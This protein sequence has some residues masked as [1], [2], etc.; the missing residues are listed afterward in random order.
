[1]QRHAKKGTGVS[2]K[3]LKESW[4]GSVE[5]IEE[6]EQQGKVLVIRAGKENQP[7][8]VFW[9][10]MDPVQME[11]QKIDEGK[12]LSCSIAFVSQAGLIAEFKTM[13]ND[14]VVPE[15]ADVVR[16]LNSGSSLFKHVS[17]LHDRQ[18]ANCA[19]VLL[20]TTGLSAHYRGTCSY[21]LPCGSCEAATKEEAAQG[22]QSKANQDHQHTYPRRRPFHG[23]STNATIMPY[24]CHH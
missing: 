13:W 24:L 1:V 11:E 22:S 6:L 5:A 20:L 2:V 3:S 14:Q 12:S 21:H 8:F 9:N 10:T 18:V 17:T 23:L 16:A 7:R 4:K 19:S 15:D